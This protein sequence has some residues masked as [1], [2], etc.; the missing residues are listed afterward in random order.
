MDGEP[1]QDLL[2]HMEIVVHSV[3][4]ITVTVAQVMVAIAMAV[5]VVLVEDTIHTV[6]VQVIIAQVDL[7]VV[8]IHLV[9]IDK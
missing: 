9:D 5:L 6:A 7:A 2:L 4:T 3:T 1:L 8:L